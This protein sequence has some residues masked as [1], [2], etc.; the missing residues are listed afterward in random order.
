MVIVGPMSF[1]KPD[2]PLTVHVPSAAEDRPSWPGVAAIAVLGFAVGVAWPRLAG[3]RL[4]PS[5]PDGPSA[6]A[7]S[8]PAAP[9]SSGPVASSVAAPAVPAALPVPASSVVA[10]PAAT[11]AASPAHVS[12]PRGAIFACK[13]ADGESLK[14]PECGAVPGLDGVVQPRLQRL[15]DCP[16]AANTSGTLHLVVRAD[17]ARDA[18][19]ADLG[20]EKGVASSAA[21]LTCAKGVLSSATIKSLTHEN[22]RYSVAYNVRFGA[23]GAVSAAGAAGGTSGDAP[24]S[25]G[26]ATSVAGAS[27]ANT[28]PPSIGA[29]DASA[30][31]E[32]NVG[33]VRDAPHTGGKVVARLAKGTSLKV[34]AP[35]DGWYPVQ[36]GDGFAS[37]GWLFHGA[38][39]R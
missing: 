27:G 11:A 17:F 33:I 29:G 10:A 2:G 6:S 16:D 23:S 28:P 26:G 32:W 5:V 14:G 39:G 4:G 7:S 24:A 36:Y 3:V 1:R 15:A 18:L 37:S 30:Q 19:T 22:A 21:L 20:R 9:P 25:G 34:G 35:K 13:T 31:V 8:E 12:V 38:I